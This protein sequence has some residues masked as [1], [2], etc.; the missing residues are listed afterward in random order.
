LEFGDFS[1]DINARDLRIRM[2]CWL[3]VGFSWL[4]YYVVLAKEEGKRGN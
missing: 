4:I 1:E 3:F 2:G